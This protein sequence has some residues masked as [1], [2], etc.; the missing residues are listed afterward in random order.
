MSTNKT[1]D[2]YTVSIR[3]KKLGAFLAL[4]LAYVET[5]GS[6]PGLITFLFYIIQ[7]RVHSQVSHE[8]I[9]AFV[10]R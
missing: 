3:K 4:S 1:F 9:I 10:V 5:E 8:S 6:L 2:E 7:L